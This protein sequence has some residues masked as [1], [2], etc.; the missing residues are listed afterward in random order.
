MGDYSKEATKAIPSVRYNPKIALLSKQQKAIHVLSTEIGTGKYTYVL[1]VVAKYGKQPKCSL[2]N[3]IMVCPVN[4][5]LVK[6][7][8]LARSFSYILLMTKHTTHTLY[9]STILFI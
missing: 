9:G 1:F 3:R 7:Q 5:M 4:K 6:Y 8:S 2:K